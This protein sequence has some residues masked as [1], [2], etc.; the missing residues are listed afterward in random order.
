MDTMESGAEV[1][2]QTG[3]A[4]SE[5]SSQMGQSI[6]EIGGQVDQFQV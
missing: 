3:N 6:D 2:R 1:I 5:I 4:L